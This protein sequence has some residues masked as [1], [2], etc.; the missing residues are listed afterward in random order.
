[1]LS[2]LASPR[3][4][5][6]LLFAGSAAFVH[7]RGRSRHKFLRQLTDHSSFLAP[8]N[9]PFY[10]MSK[11]HPRPYL[12]PGR[13]PELSVLRD[14]WEAIRDEGLRLL[15]DGY[16]RAARDYNDVGFNS[17]FR[18]GWKRFYVKWYD[19]PLSSARD[20]CPKTVALIAGVPKVN[21][22]MFALLPPGGKL[23]RHRDPFAGSLRYHLGLSTPNSE[24]CFIEVDGKRYYWKDGEDVVFDETFLHSAENKTGQSRLILFCDVER[25]VWT[26]A[27]AAVNHVVC[28]R[29]MRAAATENVPGERIGLLNRI[30][31]RVYK[32]RLAG[33][34]MKKWNQPV[35]YVTKFALFGGLLYLAFFV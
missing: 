24:Q 4:W 23:G 29:L 13:I 18:A 7:F 8:L 16:V 33:K 28:T 14:N 26:R 10:L 25:P 11:V 1:M 30:F 12:D 17:F 27:F 20:L 5:V 34:R 15:D 35:Y 22:A 32:I 9:L 2:I 6:F 19:V 21:A 31:G 3:L